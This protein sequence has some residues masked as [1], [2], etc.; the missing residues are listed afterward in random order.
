MASSNL[1]KA[2]WVGPFDAQIS[3]KVT[4][5]PGDE[6]EVSPDD[7]KSGHWEAV[8]TAAKKVEKEA[9]QTPAPEKVEA[10]AA[11]ENGD[12]T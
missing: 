6:Y 3:G 1:V 12:A 8:G 11:A 2:R 4:L 5:T 9:V 7:L 10:D